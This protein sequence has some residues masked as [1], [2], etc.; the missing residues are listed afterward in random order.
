MN[1][2]STNMDRMKVCVIH[3]KKGIM[4]DVGAL[5]RI[6]NLY[7]YFYMELYTQF[8]CCEYSEACKSGKSLENYS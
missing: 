6:K 4:V 5:E 8:V 3:Y 7:R 1:H 2:V